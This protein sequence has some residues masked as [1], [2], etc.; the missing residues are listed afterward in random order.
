[1]RAF[2]GL[3]VVDFTRALSGPMS[4]QML[5]LLDA[6]V[7]KVEPP[8]D[9]DQL[10]GVLTNQELAEKR[11]SPAFL[12]GNLNKRSLALDLKSPL[13]RKAAAKLVAGADVVIENFVPGTARKLGIDYDTVR[14]TNPDVI[15]CSISGY[16][17]SGPRT[18]EKA[19][20]S[21]IQAD[22][23]I[24]S[25]T[26]FPETGP[27]RVGFMLVDVATGI[28]A[29][30]AIAAA[31]YRRA[32]SGKGQYLDVAM[33]D[34]ALQLMC[35][36][37]ADYLARRQ[38]PPLMGNDSPMAQPTAGTFETA[39]GTILLATLTPRHQ[40]QTFTALGLEDLLTDP[41]FS[42]ELARHKHLAEGRALIQAVLSGKATRDWLL[43]L[44]NH[45]VPVQAVRGLDEALSDP[46]LAHRGLL[47][48]AGNLEHVS[49]TTT[50]LGAPFLANEDGPLT[51]ARP[52]AQVGQHS[53]E[54][55]VELGFAP[56]EI[57]NLLKTVQEQP[58]STFE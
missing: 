57:D 29:A 26:G 52:P 48:D 55:L 16:G 43:I 5:A 47:V 17:Q 53:R 18:S 4:A 49:K 54:I 23:G 35:C 15:Y 21:A 12:T 8:G 32:V 50:L 41:R 2:Q 25:L 3:R 31:L 14:Q 9:G 27:T 58:A 39:D 38:V 56:A 30:Y 37:A 36:Q 42:T 22:S 28:S 24:M 44:K 10:R 51:K 13:G 40:E 34:T 20:D 11:L 33:Y 7:I 45:G 46:Q 1:M 19:Y 6:D